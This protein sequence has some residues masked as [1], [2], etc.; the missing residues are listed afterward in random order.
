MIIHLITR[1][2]LGGAQQQVVQIT[3]SL[4]KSNKKTMIITGLSDSTSLSAKDN[5]LLELGFKKNIKIEVI[6]E[7]SDK[8]SPLKDFISIIK[9]SRL[10]QKYKP[11]ILH[12][13][14][15]K[16]GVLGRLLKVFLEISKSFIMFTAGV[17]LDQMELKQN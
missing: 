9:I 11:T 16:T 12:I 6:D 13:H 8:I 5:K 3:S 2:A 7:L 10:L 14:S 1:L 17:F 15:S 4:I